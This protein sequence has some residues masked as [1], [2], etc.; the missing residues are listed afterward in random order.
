[1]PNP[2]WTKRAAAI[3]RAENKIALTIALFRAVE[4]LAE[5]SETDEERAALLEILRAAARLKAQALRERRN[6]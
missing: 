6:A 3:E 2:G 4:A 5:L 1:M